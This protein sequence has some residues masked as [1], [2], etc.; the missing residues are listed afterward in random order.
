LSA[1]AGLFP[2]KIPLLFSS[3]FGSVTPSTKPNAP[4]SPPPF[5]GVSW[6]AA[7][8]AAAAAAVAVNLFFLPTDAKKELGFSTGGVMGPIVVGSGGGEEKGGVQGRR[9]AERELERVRRGVVW[10]GRGLEVEEGGGVV[11]VGRGG[12]SAEVELGPIEEER[13]EG[14][15]RVEACRDR[16]GEEEGVKGLVIRSSVRARGEGLFVELDCSVV[17]READ[18]LAGEAS[19][20]VGDEAGGGAGKKR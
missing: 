17:A 14:P 19:V 18:R 16:E 6:A 5:K 10:E 1:V 20:V 3:N 15:P 9:R 2:L 8:A 12:T 4:G 7:A 13:L 11:R